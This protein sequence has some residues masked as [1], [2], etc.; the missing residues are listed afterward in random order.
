MLILLSPSKTQDFEQKVTVPTTTI[1]R[2]LGE[3]Q[4]LIKQLKALSMSEL[5]QLMEISPKLAELNYHRYQQF[6]VPF[7]PDN[8]KPALTSFQGDVY[9]EIE[10]EHYTQEDFL[11]AQ[12][13]LRILSGLYGLL[14]PLDLIQPYRLEMGT[15]L[16]NARGKDLYHFWGDKITKLVNEDLATTHASALINLASQEYAGAITTAQLTQPVITPVF[17]EKRAGALKV[18]GLMAK[19]ARGAMANAIIRQRLTQPQQLKSLEMLGYRYQAS[20]SNE[21][22]WVFIR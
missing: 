19:R 20:L 1:P 5:A 18:I 3:T 11:F 8:A 16:S 14:K 12:T 6:T 10:V 7:T 2:A 21:K 22:E 17:K 13:H 9:S 15:K 4:Q